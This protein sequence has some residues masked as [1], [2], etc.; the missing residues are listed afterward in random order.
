V[1][2]GGDGSE[3]AVDAADHL[4][5]DEALLAAGAPAVR[6]ASVRGPI[7]SL[8]VGQP[9][10]PAAA[11][12]ARALGIPVVRR[13]SGGTGLL[14]LDGDLVW[15]VV[16]P[17]DDP[18]VG[19]DYARAYARLGEAVTLALD[20]LGIAARWTPAAGTSETYCLL[21]ARGHVLAVGARAIAGAA[22]HVTRHALLHH[23]TVNVHLDRRRLERLFDV[24]LDALE[25]S[26]TC[27][28]EQPRPPSPR[29]AAAAL[30]RRLGAW[31]GRP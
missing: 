30:A 9:P 29:A 16:L 27:L 5:C 8:G 15:S 21:A 18:R 23:G 28:T 17:R 11:V 20:D 2:G 4:A 24:P 31:V 22:Q 14:H 6:V 13:R 7:V 25:R 3:G 19:T 12:R 1:D 26:V 10:D